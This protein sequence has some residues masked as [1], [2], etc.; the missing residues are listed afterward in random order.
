VAV[1]IDAR[2]IGLTE[3]HVKPHLVIGYVAARHNVIPPKSEKPPAY[4]VGSDHQTD[5]PEGARRR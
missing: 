4:P 2:R 1:L 3:L 5:T